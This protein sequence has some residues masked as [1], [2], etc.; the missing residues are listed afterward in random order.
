MSERFYFTRRGL[1]NLHEKIEGLKKKLNDIQSQVAYVAE[2]CG[3]QWHDN[4]AYK[5]LEIDI[6]QMDRRLADAY[7]VLS[8]VTIVEP[9]T[10]FD[11]VTIGTRVKVI[12]DG[13][14]MRLE[15]VSFGE[16]DPDCGM[17]AYNTPI[18]SLIIGKRRGE[19]VSGTIAG[20]QTE[21]EVLEI[22]KGGEEDVH[23]S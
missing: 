3:D 19:V 13:E 18:A 6:Q 2:I 1:A 21:I 7:Q 8:K 10:N 11:R 9:P 20:R 23:S 16:S 4:P 5:S 12:Y 15:I 17:I 22:T 14:E